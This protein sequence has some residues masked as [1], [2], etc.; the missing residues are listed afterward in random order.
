MTIGHTID[1]WVDHPPRGCLLFADN[2]AFEPNTPRIKWTVLPA[3]PRQKIYVVVLRVDGQS[4]FEVPVST[5]TI[6]LRN[7]SGSYMAFTVP[8]PL[9]YT[10]EILARIPG[11]VHIL[12]GELVEGVR[13]TEELIYGNIQNIYFNSGSSDM[14]TISATRFITHRSPFEKEL[15]GISRVKKNDNGRFSVVCSIDFFL[16]PTDTAYF[17]DIMFVVDMISYVIAAEGAHME[18]EGE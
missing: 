15:Q 1:L 7:I 4:D 5:I 6:R 13:Q 12:A 17:G 10:T 11:R 16:K 2:W 14:L 8:D 9:K 3:V 18:V